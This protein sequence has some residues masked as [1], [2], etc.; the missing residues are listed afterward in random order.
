[1]RRKLTRELVGLSDDSA[2]ALYHWSAATPAV[3][4]GP[5]A[6]DAPDSADDGAAQIEPG[7]ALVAAVGQA[8]AS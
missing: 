3:D 6:A 1:M 4:S 5:S 2:D 7:A 8:K